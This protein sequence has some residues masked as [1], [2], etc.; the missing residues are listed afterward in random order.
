MIRVCCLL[1]VVGCAL[2]Y[3]TYF[4]LGVVLLVADCD[5]LFVDCWMLLDGCLLF[6]V[7]CVVCCVLFVALCFG[8]C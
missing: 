6:V 8:V 5:C 3:D 4:V 7:C 1:V 2:L